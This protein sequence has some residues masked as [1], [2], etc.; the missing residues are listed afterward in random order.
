MDRTSRWSA[1]AV[2]LLGS[3]GPTWAD[4]HCGAAVRPYAATLLDRVVLGAEALAKRI[5]ARHRAGA[6]GAW[7][8]ARVGWQRVELVLAPHFP[9]ALAAIDAW[10]AAD[11]GFHAIERLLFDDGNLAAAG[12]LGRKLVG[13]AVALRWR[14]EA[15]EL[16]AAGVIAGLNAAVADLGRARAE[17]GQSPL[18]KTSLEDMRHQLQGVETVYALSLAALSR[19]RQ[20]AL[21]ARIISHL[22]AFNGALRAPALAAIDAAAVRTLGEGLRAAF[23]EMAVLIELEGTEFRD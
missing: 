2:V 13:D 9:D 6:K 11:T 21:H 10:P 1:A 15:I 20:P 14:L 19:A 17:G 23:G 22:I 16:D 7:I 5:E 4:D 3:V 18:A 12:V 8:E